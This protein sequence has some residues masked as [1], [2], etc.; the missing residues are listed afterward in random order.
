MR[1]YDEADQQTRDNKG[2]PDEWFF[3]IS[4]PNVQTHGQKQPVVACSQ[5]GL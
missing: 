5:S 1:F 4:Q 3:R 2:Y